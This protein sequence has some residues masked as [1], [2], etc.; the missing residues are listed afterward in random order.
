MA[1]FTYKLRVRFNECDPQSVAFNANYLAYI[2]VAITDLS[3]STLT[4]L[5]PR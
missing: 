2:D 4:A 1:P 5:T 3:A